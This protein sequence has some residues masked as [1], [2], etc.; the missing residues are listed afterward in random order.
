MFKG[1][2]C[3]WMRGGTSKGGYFLRE[4][5][6]SDIQD[7]DAFLLRALGSPDPRQIDGLGGGDPLTSKVAIVSRSERPGIDVDY[8]FLQIFVDKALVSD[9]QN[10]G[11]IL[12]GVGPFAIERGLVAAEGPETRVTV[13][14]ENTGQVAV[15]TVATP[16]GSVEYEGNAKIDGVPGAHSPIPVE[17]RDTAGSSCGALLPTGE[18]ATMVDGVACTLIDNGMPCV[19][20]RA[21]EVGASGYESREELESEAFAPMRSRLEAIR[22][23]AGPLMNLGDVHDK[24]VP[25]MMLVAPPRRHGAIT[26]RSFVPHR[27]HA[28]V[29]VFGAVT[30]ATACMIEGSPAAALARVPDGRTKTI[31]IEHPT[32]QMSCLLEVDGQ[33]EVVRSALLRTARKLMDGLIF[34]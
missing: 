4:D 13:Y 6:P 33:G 18:A 9:A 14:M 17:F 5:L 32:G 20:L 2:P 22:L 3:M 21:R 11:N 29:G 25:K 16:N 30:V 1:V 7:R 12:A 10:C 19:V 34:G 27:A 24:S 31:S 28:S 8:L 23:A 26:V 15:V